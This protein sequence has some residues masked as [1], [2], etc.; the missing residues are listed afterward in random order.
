MESGWTRAALEDDEG[1]VCLVG[2]RN[3][4]L[5]ISNNV[6]SSDASF[7]SYA[8]DPVTEAIEQVLPDDCRKWKEFNCTRMWVFNDRSQSVNE[9]LALI[10]DAILAEKE[11]LV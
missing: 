6:N 4:A 10:D 3:I 9:V 7:I 5:G 8:C 2:A 1:R 11:K